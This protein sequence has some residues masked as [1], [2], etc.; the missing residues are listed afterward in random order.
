[1]KTKEKTGLV[2]LSQ[3][4]TRLMLVLPLLLFAFSFA[5][6]AQEK[7]KKQAGIQFIENK[8]A[9]ATVKAKEQGKLIFVDAFAAWCVPCK[10][11]RKTTFKDPKV[12]AYFNDHFIS[13]ALDAEKGEGIPFATKYEVQGYP[14]LYFIDT[15]GNLIA[16]NEGLIAADALLALADKVTKSDSQNKK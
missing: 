13:V 11:L 6:H 5:A 10:Q 3:A 7:T 4:L 15:E 9:D 2:I 12:A 1:M 8:L 14:S 16:K